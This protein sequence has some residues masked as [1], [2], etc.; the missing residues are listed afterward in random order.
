[1]TSKDERNLVERRIAAAEMNRLAHALVK[2]CANP[3]VLEAIGVEAKRLADTLEAEP[4]NERSLDFIAHAEQAGATWEGDAPFAPRGEF[5][6]MFH[7]SPVSGSLNPLNMGLKIA[8]FD[9]HTVGRVTLAPGW[10]GAPGRSHGGVVAAIVDEVLGAMLPVL[11]IVAFTGELTLRYVGPC[12]MG[13]P[14]EFTARMTGRDGR[15]IFL[16][17]TGSDPDGSTFVEATSTFIE[18]DVEQFRGDDS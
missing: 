10:Q 2:H 16:A 5:V 12:P 13:V 9:D 17:C 15:K 11:K 18:T 1:V 6:D 7:D 8:T 4:E 3:E 14:L